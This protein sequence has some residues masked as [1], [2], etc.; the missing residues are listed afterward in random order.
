MRLLNGFLLVMAILAGASYAQ[1]RCEPNEADDLLVQTFGNKECMRTAALQHPFFSQA[2]AKACEDG[3]YDAQ[4]TG[5]TTCYQP[6]IDRYKKDLQA[7]AD[8]PDCGL[9]EQKKKEDNAK[10]G[11]EGACEWVH[12]ETVNVKCGGVEK[13]QLCGA[14]GA[15][16]ICTGRVRCHKQFRVA[17]S[18]YDRPYWNSGV[19]EVA[20]MTKTGKCD[21][22]GA[23]TMNDYFSE[24]N[25]KSQNEIHIYTNDGVMLPE[26]QKS[27]DGIRNDGTK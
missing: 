21:G 1:A 24:E 3:C 17:G 12:R 4:F 9:N 8:K 19:F 6:V 7:M 20:A 14:T 23:P 11:P 10:K 27:L 25:P 16:G 18:Y 5:D 13:A 22:P 26:F 15:K 2:V